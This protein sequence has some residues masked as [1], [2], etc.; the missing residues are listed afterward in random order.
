MAILVSSLEFIREKTEK[1]NLVYNIK[2][3]IFPLIIG[4]L[5]F[6]A[7]FFSS[8]VAYFIFYWSYVPSVGISKDVHLQFGYR[9][10]I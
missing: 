6:S 2:R 10:G 1:W 8:S 7:L 9:S 3:T 4:T 5:I